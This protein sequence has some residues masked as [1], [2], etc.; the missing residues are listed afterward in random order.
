MVPVLSVFSPVWSRSFQ[1]ETG[2]TQF[3]CKDR[4]SLKSPK[5]RLFLFQSKRRDQRIAL[6]QAAEGSPLFLFAYRAMKS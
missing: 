2:L 1:S 4:K 6:L 3:F 5:G